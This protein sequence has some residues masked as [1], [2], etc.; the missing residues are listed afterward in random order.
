V[1]RRLADLELVLGT[2]RETE[3]NIKVLVTGAPPGRPRRRA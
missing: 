2:R 1:G 3:V